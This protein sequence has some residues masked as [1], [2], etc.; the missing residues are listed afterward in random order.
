MLRHFVCSIPR[1][2]VYYY[3][4]GYL[5]GLSGDSLIDQPVVY[6]GQ[7]EPVRSILLLFP[8]AAE[9]GKRFPR[10]ISLANVALIRST[11]GSGL[12]RFNT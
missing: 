12:L 7:I 2:P 10:Y 5:I 4:Y 1:P 11:G 8:P 3:I 6:I 9:G